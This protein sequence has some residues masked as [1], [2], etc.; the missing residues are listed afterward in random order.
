V[1]P[2]CSPALLPCWRLQGQIS[3]L[4]GWMDRILSAE[5]WTR[6]SKQRAG[7][8]RFALLPATMLLPAC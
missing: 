1:L 7:G 4:G 5:D 3:M 2:A 6:V 8:S